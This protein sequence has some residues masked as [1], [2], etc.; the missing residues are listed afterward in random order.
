LALIKDTAG[1]QI[2]FPFIA[3]SIDACDREVMLYIASTKGIDGQL[4]A[5]HP[6]RV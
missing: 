1:V 2:V 3:F 5:S 4:D 6:R